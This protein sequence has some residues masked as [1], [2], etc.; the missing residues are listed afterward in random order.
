MAMRI[1]RYLASHNNIHISKVYHAYF[2]PLEWTVV[3]RED[4]A[5]YA[6][7]ICNK[8]DNERIVG[9]HFLGP[10]AGEVIQGFAL[11]MTCKATKEDLERTVGIHPTVAE[12]LVLLNIT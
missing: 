5:C 2:K 6:K 12:E 8:K 10:H 9:I 7:V 11:A 3:H 1:L 4:N